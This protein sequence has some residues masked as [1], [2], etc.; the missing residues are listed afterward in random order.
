MFMYLFERI[1]KREEIALLSTASFSP[2]TAVAR[3][4]Q[5]QSQELPIGLSHMGA[6]TT[7]LGRFPKHSRKE[8]NLEVEH[9]DLNRHPYRILASLYPLFHIPHS[10]FFLQLLD[11]ILISHVR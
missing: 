6:G 1:S 9:L 7:H 5:A 11:E 4:G 8:L 3:P 2:M 10:S